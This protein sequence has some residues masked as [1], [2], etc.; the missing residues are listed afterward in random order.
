MWQT[1]SQTNLKAG[2]RLR[3]MRNFAN[4][5]DSDFKFDF[6]KRVKI[7][8]TLPSR[9]LSFASTTKPHFLFHLETSPSLPSGIIS[10]SFVLDYLFFPSFFSSIQNSL[11]LSI[12]RLVLCLHFLSCILF[13]SFSYDLSFSFR[14]VPLFI[15]LLGSSLCLPS[16]TRSSFS[17]IGYSLSLPSKSFQ[18]FYSPLQCN[19]LIFYKFFSYISSTQLSKCLSFRLPAI[20]ILLAYEYIH[21]ADH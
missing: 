6:T 20:P 18:R 12:F 16:W 21:I 11:S 1:K 19:L 3:K 5:Y 15:F 7:F 10:F 8:F 13:F 2:K 4:K 14:S 9:I 17:P